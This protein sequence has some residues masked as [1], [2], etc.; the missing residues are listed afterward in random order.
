[1][2]KQ[3]DDLFTVEK[4]LAIIRSMFSLSIVG[5]TEAWIKLKLQELG[6]PQI[7]GGFLHVKFGDIVFARFTSI[8]ERDAAIGTLNRTKIQID[9][10]LAWAR[11]DAKEYVRACEIF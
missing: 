7:L 4:P 6:A 1:M 2:Q 5:A 11:A 10:K 3:I 8:S 9:S